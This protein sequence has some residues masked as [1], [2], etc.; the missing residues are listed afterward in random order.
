MRKSNFC[1][2][3]FVALMALF[4]TTL[5]F[6]VQSIETDISNRSMVAAKAAGQN[7][8]ILDADGRDLTLKGEAP[9]HHAK[10]ATFK[11]VKAVWGV[12]TVDDKTTVALKKV[13]VAIPAV[14]PPQDSSRLDT[15]GWRIERLNDGVL[16]SGVVPDA[17]TQIILRDRAH[18]LFPNSVVDETHI[19]NAGPYT[20][21]RQV[22]E[23]A[24]TQIYTVRTGSA[25]LYGGKLVVEG[26][27]D[28]RE[29]KTQLESALERDLPEGFSGIARIEAVD[30]DDFTDEG[31]RLCRM[32]FDR[33]LSSRTIE[34]ESGS[35]ALKAA[36]N[37][38][39]DELA[40]TASQCPS[41][42][43]EISGHTDSTGASDKNM[44]LS[45]GRAMAVLGHLKKAGIADDR[46]TAV[47]FGAALPLE[48]NATE[49]GRA[50]NR[51]IEF[52]VKK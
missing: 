11:I 47:G 43:I 21:W 24:I 25:T 35:V 17:A 39:L 4:A 51:R 34:F 49:A 28:D 3:I 20:G 37:S 27:T 6:R 13:P 26:T 22:A 10:D 38:L 46:L 36:N 42:L 7:W 50:R 32:A 44:S 33:L 23:L 18:Q 29:R 30:M 1:L 16:L 45:H 52:K 40:L 31:S 41:A 5:Y 2:T 15:D 9:T 19:G 8:T 14:S 48:N 12:R